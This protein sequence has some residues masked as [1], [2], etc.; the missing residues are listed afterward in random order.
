MEK[1]NEK[2]KKR[3]I[4]DIIRAFNGLYIFRTKRRKKIEVSFSNFKAPFFLF[5]SDRAICQTKPNQTKKKRNI[6]Q[7]KK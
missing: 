1:G 6:I 4:K 7:F 5:S 2:G 3:S